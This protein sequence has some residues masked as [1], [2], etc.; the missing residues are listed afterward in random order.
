MLS[1]FSFEITPELTRSNKGFPDT[2][3]NLGIG[4]IVSPCPPMTI[5]SISFTGTFNSSDKKSLNLELSNIPA[6]PTTFLAAS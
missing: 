4:T 3:V 2:L 6:I 5:A 1:S